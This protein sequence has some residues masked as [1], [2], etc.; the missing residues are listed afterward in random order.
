MAISK[1]LKK[2][3]TCCGQI[4]DNV[5][6]LCRASIRLQSDVE[7]LIQTILE[8]QIKLAKIIPGNPSPTEL[9]ALRHNVTVSSGPSIS[10]PAPEDLDDTDKLYARR[11]KFFLQEWLQNQ[12][13]VQ[14]FDLTSVKLIYPRAGSSCCRKI[15]HHLEAENPDWALQ[16]YGNID[17]RIKHDALTSLRTMATMN[18]IPTGRCTNFWLEDTLLEYFY[19]KWQQLKKRK[20]DMQRIQEVQAQKRPRMLLPATLT[21]EAFEESPSSSSSAN[22]RPYGV[23]S[24][25]EALLLSFFKICHNI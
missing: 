5:I 14:L 24:V 12:V 4:A 3:S 11:L 6:E 15:V 9:P 25:G 20:L 13:T 7:L 2:I 22:K 10:K 17:H 8:C 18:G 23:F 19:Y 21:P 16:A 1:E